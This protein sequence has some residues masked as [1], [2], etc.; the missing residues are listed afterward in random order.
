M[1]VSVARWRIAIFAVSLAAAAAEQEQGGAATVVVEPGARYRANWLY[2]FV[3]GTHWRD[4]WTTPVRVPVLELR[5]F[6]GGMAP[7]RRG[8]GLQ[9]M[10]LRL[11][12]AGG[13]T[14]AF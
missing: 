13:H 1:L 9:T 2:R 5:T 8:G 4:D 7:V 14:Y 11:K 10:N 12:S 3:F 6:D